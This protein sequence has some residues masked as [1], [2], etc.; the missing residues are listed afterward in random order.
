M[1]HA[2]I[3]TSPKFSQTPDQKQVKVIA[4]VMI[5][6]FYC[7]STY[8]RQSSR[9]AILMLC[10]QLYHTIMVKLAICMKPP[11][12]YSYYFMCMCVFMQVYHKTIFLTPPDQ[13]QFKI[14]ASLITKN[15]EQSYLFCVF[16]YT[17][18]FWLDQPYARSPNGGSH[19]SYV[20]VAY[21]R[22]IILIHTD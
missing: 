19:T 5:K 6:H 1:I 13:K 21:N 7:F 11:A 20:Y 12:R 2:V 9:F 3:K 8:R 15:D 4:S 22:T 18:L 16:S 10:I 17:I 14:T